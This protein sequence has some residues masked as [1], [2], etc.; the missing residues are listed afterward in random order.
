MTPR[1]PCVPH[2]DEVGLNGVD[3]REDLFPRRAGS[4][5]GVGGRERVA[6]TLEFSIKLVPSRFLE[7]NQQ[8]RA[9]HR[10]ARIHVDGELARV[11]KRK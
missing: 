2:H 7:R 11:H 5:D 1:R 9:A 4:E 10:H 3:R 6:D 8:V